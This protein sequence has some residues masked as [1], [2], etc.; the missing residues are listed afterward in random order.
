MRFTIQLVIDDENGPETIEE[1]IQ[2]DKGFDDNSV[3]GLTLPE[4]KEMMQILQAKIIRQQA[5]KRAESVRICLSCEKKQK[6]KGYHSLQYR[7]LFGIVLLSSPRFFHCQCDVND[8][9][10]FSPLSNWLESKNSPELQYIE[11]KWASLMSYELTAELLKEAFPVGQT[12]NAATVRNHLHHTAKR[13]ELELEGKSEYIS[14]CQNEWA[15]LPRPDKPITVG[16]D[17][18]YLKNWHKKSKNFEIIV[19]KS[20]SETRAAKRFGLVQKLDSHPKRRL[21]NV[22][23]SQGMQENQ[24][25]TFLSDGADN[26]RDLQH[27]MYPESEHVLDWFHITMRITVLHQFAKGL[28]KSDPEQ[29][30]ELKKHLESIKWYLWHGNVKRA[31][32]RLDDCYWIADDEAL[33]YR[34]KKKLAKHIDEL[35]TYVENNSHLIVNYGEKWRY[36]EAI[37]TGFVE[38]TINEVVTKRMVKKQQMQW[39][40]EGAHYLLQTRVAVLNNDLHEYFERWYPS[41]SINA[42]DKTLTPELQK[43]V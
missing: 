18:G 20:F 15:K 35:Q 40:Y 11:T 17:G 16:I 43:A 6:L 25:I 24:Q 13:Q 12:L 14:G 28:I 36:G 37:S 30:A 22:L 33:T 2:L 21:I 32:D 31:L 10:S 34:N 19:G 5:K 27:I 41:F 39:T 4:S 7:T 26:V 38:S 3:V 8:T 1:I 29:G 23:K 42:Q 9:K